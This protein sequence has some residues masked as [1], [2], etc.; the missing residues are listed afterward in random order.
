MLNYGFNNYKKYSIIDGSEKMNVPID[1]AEKEIVELKYDDSV[2]L[3]LSENEKANK[4]Y[5]GMQCE[6]I[7]N[8]LWSETIRE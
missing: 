5:S 1:K 7:G 2:D 8:S 4:I 6:I 3:L